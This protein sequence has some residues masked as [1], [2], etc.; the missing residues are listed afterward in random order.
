MDGFE[1]TTKRNLD[2]VWANFFYVANIPFVV[3]RNPAFKEAVKKIAKCNAGFTPPLY[4]DLCHKLLDTAKTEI[5]TK[6]HNRTKD[7]I[8]KF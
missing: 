3:V 6:L 5:K 1:S 2:V 7:S 4:H 8:R